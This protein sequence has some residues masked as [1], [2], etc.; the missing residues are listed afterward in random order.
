M[1][2]I[3]DKTREWSERFGSI[4]RLSPL[5]QYPQIY[6]GAVGGLEH[7]ISADNGAYYME[8]WRDGGD[9]YYATTGAAI[10]PL[11]GLAKGARLDEA[12]DRFFVLMAKVEKARDARPA[13]D[14][15]QRDGQRPQ[16]KAIPKKL[17]RLAGVR[18]NIVEKVD[19]EIGP[20]LSVG[21]RKPSDLS[22]ESSMRKL[23]KLLVADVVRKIGADPKDYSWKPPTTKPKPKACPGCP[24]K[25]GK[26]VVALTGNQPG[27]GRVK[28]ARTRV[29]DPMKPAKSPAPPKEYRSP[30]GFSGR[31]MGQPGVPG[32]SHS[33]AA[34]GSGRFGK[35]G[36]LGQKTTHRR[37]Q[38]NFGRPAGLGKGRKVD[39]LEGGRVGAGGRITP[40]K[41]ATGGPGQPTSYGSTG[42]PQYR[43]GR[44]QRKPGQ[45]FWVSQ[46]GEG[47]TRL[48]NKA[49]LCD[50]VAKTMKAVRSH[51]KDIRGRP[52]GTPG[53]QHP[54]KTGP[55]VVK[56]VAG[57]PA[58]K[59]TTA[60][61]EEERFRRG[62]ASAK[63][64]K[65]MH[66]GQRMG[67]S[68]ESTG[69]W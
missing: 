58:P 26:N 54:H 62:G 35:A 18:K 53:H 27:S 20:S 45:S 29:T 63:P 46:R 11:P 1:A 47:K 38:P 4:L 49:C 41:P 32:A 31:R 8:M 10:K 51:V 7:V 55:T 16:R 15:G 57:K 67:G 22:P 56:K 48:T 6:K 13:R 43:Y 37:A 60:P 52:A 66:P 44:K 34:R 68:L 19:P 30:Q 21:H 69:G 64:I 33:G 59:P 39:D 2:E 17:K 24:H 12:L 61:T 5:T 9:Q 23:A 36:P 42:Q 40:V 50:E 65:P 25:V 14:D 3:Q 28:P